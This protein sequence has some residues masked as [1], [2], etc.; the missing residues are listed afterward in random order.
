MS[1][2]E[3]ESFI[4][5]WHVHCTMWKKLEP[6]VFESLDSPDYYIH[7]AS[8]SLWRIVYVETG[9]CSVGF[10]QRRTGTRGREK[11]NIWGST[12]RSISFK[13]HSLRPSLGPFFWRGTL[14]AHTIASYAMALTSTLIGDPLSRGFS[15]LIKITWTNI[16]TNMKNKEKHMPITF[17]TGK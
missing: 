14:V 3:H 1:F 15:L 8:K 6:Y 12:A 7:N 17:S 4:K 13:V 2:I 5:S 9:T 10:T 16:R 11:W